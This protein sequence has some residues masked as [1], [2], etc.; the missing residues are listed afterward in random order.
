MIYF[1]NRGF[2]KYIYI[3]VIFTVERLKKIKV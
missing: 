3:D 1:K 2:K